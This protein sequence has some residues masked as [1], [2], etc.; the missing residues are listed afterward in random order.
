MIQGTI[1]PTKHITVPRFLTIAL[2]MPINYNN[3]HVT[4]SEFLKPEN[5]KSR[6][7]CSLIFELR[8][9]SQGFVSLSSSNPT[10]KYIPNAM[11]ITEGQTIFLKLAIYQLIQPLLGE[12]D[13]THCLRKMTIDIQTEILHHQ[14]VLCQKWGS[15]QVQSGF[16]QVPSTGLEEEFQLK[17]NKLHQTLKTF[18]VKL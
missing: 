15:L 12:I 8:S 17:W 4:S 13:E 10:S 6:C 1:T 5:M 7:L 9:R 16:C 18:H 11:E 14:W 2:I 3:N